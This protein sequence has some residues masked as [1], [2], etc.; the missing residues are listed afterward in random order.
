MVNVSRRIRVHTWAA[1]RA[2]DGVPGAG[3]GFSATDGCLKG[4]LDADAVVAGVGSPFQRYGKA[5]G[6]ASMRVAVVMRA[7]LL[8]VNFDQVRVFSR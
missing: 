8:S 1:R 6:G 3:V 5:L 4:M 7:C 2:L